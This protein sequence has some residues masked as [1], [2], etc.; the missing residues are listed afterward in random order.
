MW[1]EV[2]L[3]PDRLLDRGAALALDVARNRQAALAGA[4]L[5]RDA[6]A[7]SFRA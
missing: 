2:H 3:L 7:A 4:L 5:E 6:V 1:R